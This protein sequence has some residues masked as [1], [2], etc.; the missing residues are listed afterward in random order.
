M[1]RF[2]KLWSF[3]NF[4]LFLFFNIILHLYNIEVWKGKKNVTMTWKEIINYKLPPIVIW[5]KNNCLKKCLDFLNHE[6]LFF[7][8][9]S[10]LSS[11][12][13]YWFLFVFIFQH[14]FTL[15]Q[16]W[17]LKRKKKLWQWLERNFQFYVIFRC[18]S[19]L[20]QKQ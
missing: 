13:F 7:L 20:D 9:I 10:I 4:Y 11:F 17:S 16:Y 19:L 14:Y 18:D 8:L 6:V 12:F 1:L 15:I 5:F 3:I 2:M